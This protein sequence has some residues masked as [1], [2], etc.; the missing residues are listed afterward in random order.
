[1]S[2]INLGIKSLSHSQPQCKL[3]NTARPDSISVFLLE[4]LIC[5]PHAFAYLV[6][7]CELNSANI[8]NRFFVVSP[9]DS[10]LGSSDLKILIRIVTCP[11]T[12]P[13]RYGFTMEDAMAKNKRNSTWIVRLAFHGLHAVLRHWTPPKRGTQEFW[14]PNY[15]HP[16]GLPNIKPVEYFCCPA[17]S[18]LI[19][20]FFDIMWCR[21]WTWGISPI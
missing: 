18:L 12:H 9:L 14:S 8:D 13:I 10:I 20:P 17:R 2:F 4:L 21:Q 16:R 11:G 1:M 3:W 15:D 5:S 7:A 6:L 19:V